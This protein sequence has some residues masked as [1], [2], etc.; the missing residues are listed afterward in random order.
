MDIYYSSDIWEKN[1][2]KLNSDFDGHFGFNYACCHPCHMAYFQ[3]SVYLP[4]T[5][6]SEITSLVGM[7]VNTP[8]M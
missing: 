6:I 4:S 8:S 3:T 5:Q 7:S 1:L 2:Q